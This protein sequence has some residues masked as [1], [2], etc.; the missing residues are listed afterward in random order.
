[1]FITGL[2]DPLRTD[3]ALQQ[4]T[5]LDDAVNFTRAYE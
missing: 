4:P 3:V 1:L 5:S 2:D